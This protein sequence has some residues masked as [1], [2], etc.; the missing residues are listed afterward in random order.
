MWR[1]HVRTRVAIHLVAPVVALLA[2]TACSSDDEPGASA[3]PGA[4]RLG[5]PSATLTEITVP[6]AEF[7]ETAAKIAEAQ[8]ELYAGT[9][10]DRAIDTLAAELEALKDGAPDDV[11][12]ALDTLV[13]GFRDAEELLADPSAADQE[14]L[15]EV[16]AELSAAGQKVTAYVVA[17]C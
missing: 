10:D 14:A 12:D 13:D 2:L 9:G 16:A 1:N 6:C 5:T 7:Q 11:Q 15:A 4:T 8:S 17:Q 3:S